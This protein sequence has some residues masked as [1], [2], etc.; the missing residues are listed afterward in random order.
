MINNITSVF[1]P[2]PHLSQY[3]DNPP[4]QFCTWREVEVEEDRVCS[5]LIPVDLGA[6]IELVI[7]DEGEVRL[8][9]LAI[10]TNSETFQSK[11]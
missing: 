1:P 10:E 8:P 5:H 4:D 7:I 2:S 6:V 9:N 11:C 3:H